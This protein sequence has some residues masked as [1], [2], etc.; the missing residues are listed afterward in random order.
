[1]FAFTSGG[2]TSASIVL[3]AT[4]QDIT[5]VLPSS[6]PNAGDIRE[7]RVTFVDRDAADAPFSDCVDLPVTLISVGDPK[8]GTASCTRTFDIGSADSKPFTIGIVVNRYYTRN[9]SADNG[10]LEIAK[11]TGDFITGGGYI[12]AQSSSGQYAADAGSRTNYGFNVKYNKNKTNLQGHL[13]VIFR[14]GG[15]TYQIKTTAT[16]SLG[17]TYK[18]ATGTCAGPVTS[19][20]W[21]FADFRSKANLTDVTNPLAPIS[22]GGGLTAQ[23]TMTD[24]GEPGSADSIGITLWNGNTLLFSSRWTTKTEETVVGGGNLVVH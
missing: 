9:D 7:A 20:C 3:R 1:M 12:V 13:N 24:K 11:P 6:D 8:V 19:T 22:M 17:I 14:K 5:A 23:V 4:I 10:V 21:G 18:T 2:G 15:K 16:D